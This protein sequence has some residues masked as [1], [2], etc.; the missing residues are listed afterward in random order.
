MV[1]VGAWV[2]VILL[3]GL[4]RVRSSNGGGVGGRGLVG[5]YW[6]RWRA[7]LVGDGVFLVG[8]TMFCMI[9]M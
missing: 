5:G 3:L 7:W 8:G 6:R 1:G 9:P 4:C 2:W